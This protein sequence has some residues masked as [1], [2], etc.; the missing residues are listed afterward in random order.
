MIFKIIALVL[1]AAFYAC[2]FMKMLGQK[3]KGIKT[4]QIGNGKTGFVK[5]VECT[6]MVSTVLVVVVELIS[7]ILGTTLLPPWARWLGVGFAAV[8]VVVFITAIITMRDS[9]RAGVP[10][11][12]K[13]KLVTSGIFSISRNPAFLGFDLVYLGILLMFFN[14]VLFPVSIFAA[15]MFHLQIVNVEEDFLL[16]SFGEDYLIYRKKVNRYL[17]RKAKGKAKPIII[18]VICVILSVPLIILPATTVIVYESIFG[19]RYET[20]SWLEFSV[21][22]YEGLQMERSDFQSE[23]V[24]LAGYKY[25]KANQEIKGVV[26]IAHGLGGGGHNT[27]MPFIDYFASNG[28]YVFAYDARGNDNSGGDA[29]DGLPQGIICLDNALHHVVAIEEYQDL[30]VTL[31]GHSW[32]GYSVGNVL[33]MHPDIKAAVII[34]GFNESED[35]L[36]YQGQQMA[37]TGVHILMPYLKLYERIK[38]GKEFTAVSAI[39]GL[40]KTNAGIMVVHSK[41]DATVPTKYGYDKFYEA[42]GN[43]DRFEFVLYEDKGHDYL[44]YSEAA[45]AYREQLNADYKSYVEDNGREYSA[46]TKEEFMNGYLDNKQCFE[47]DPILMKQILNMFDTYC[48]EGGSR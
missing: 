40:E 39:Q 33:N 7:I 34:A 22:D 27:Y 16:E 5:W 6:M 35:L 9:W 28:Y 41:D 44:F 19:E 11:S 30:P 8:G 20:A 13:T 48:G 36:E 18:S 10:N 31:F 26:I 24:T 2:Y 14:W 42:F 45:W 3:K 23:D 29:V 1:M 25:S 17:G 21:E 32:G 37:G 12:E 46:E 43:S 15:L 4:T 38:F 47:P